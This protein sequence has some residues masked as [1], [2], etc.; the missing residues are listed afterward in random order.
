MTTKKRTAKYTR[1]RAAE[2]LAEREA[3]KKP[4]P[5]LR[6]VP[7]AHAPRSLLDL[8]V[9]KPYP[10][11]M[12]LWRIVLQMPEPPE[13]SEGGIVIPDEYRDRKEFMGYVGYVIDMGPLCYQAVTRSGIDLSKANKVK[14]GDWAQIGKHDGEKFRTSDGT[15]Y[16]VVA[17][18]QIIGPVENPELF[19]CMNF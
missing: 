19:E 2:E 3:E 13:M 10:T 8:F 4:R 5:A 18:T 1:D 9:P 6:A 11:K 14:I 7:D 12:D 15:L 16:V 17:D